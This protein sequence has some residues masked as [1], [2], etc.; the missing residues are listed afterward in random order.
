[1]EP[2]WHRQA[3]PW[4]GP[5]SL[6]AHPLASGPHSHILE[7]QAPELRVWVQLPHREILA[8][9]GM[10]LPKLAF[11]TPSPLKK[12]SSPSFYRGD[13]STPLIPNQEGHNVDPGLPLIHVGQRVTD[14][15]LSQRVGSNVGG[16]SGSWGT[17]RA[18]CVHP[19]G[20]FP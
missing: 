12:A 17:H 16:G 9:F 1:M 8:H 15:F 4:P 10:E 20:A 19:V 14:R 3:P 11:L 13:P 18:C 7:A 5:C 2:D 6:S